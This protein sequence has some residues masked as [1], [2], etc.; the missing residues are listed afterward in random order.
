[1][2][3]NCS[4]G[5]KNFGSICASLSS[6]PSHLS[7]ITNI[8]PFATLFENKVWEVHFFIKKLVYIHHKSTKKLL[9]NNILDHRDRNFFQFVSLFVQIGAEKLQNPLIKII[10]LYR[11]YIRRK[12]DK[13]IVELNWDGKGRLTL[14]RLVDMLWNVYDK[15]IWTNMNIKRLKNNKN[16]WQFYQTIQKLIITLILNVP[17]C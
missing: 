3:K 2:R 6:S 12:I 11:L 17:K 16:R 15:S 10:L 5:Q 8:N 1:M 9:T 4:Y 14:I 13:L 7:H